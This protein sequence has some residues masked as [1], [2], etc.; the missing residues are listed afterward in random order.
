MSTSTEEL[1]DDFFGNDE[2]DFNEIIECLK[3]SKDFVRGLLNNYTRYTHRALTH[4]EQRCIFRDAFK[5]IDAVHNTYLK[6][7]IT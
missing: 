4:Q 1:L 2:S 7:H 6:R 5:L 3:D